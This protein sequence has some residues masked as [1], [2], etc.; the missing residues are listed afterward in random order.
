MG[1]SS[2][3]VGWGVAGGVSVGMLVA[4]GVTVLVGAGVGSATVPVAFN[5]KKVMIAPIAR[6]SIKIPSAMG[7]FKVISGR[8]GSETPADFALEAGTGWVRFLPQTGHFCAESLTRE[9]QVGHNF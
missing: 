1:G 5:A 4:V 7:R 2:A 9:P 3:G 8:R 6:T